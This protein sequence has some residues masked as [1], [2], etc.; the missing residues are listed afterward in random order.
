[1]RPCISRLMSAPNS[2]QRRRPSPFPISVTLVAGSSF[3]FLCRRLR[4]GRSAVPLRS[5]CQLL[6]PVDYIVL[7]RL[8]ISFSVLG[9][10][11]KM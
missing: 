2:I 10:R 7:R 8:L 5:S 9:C 6:P 1:M 3:W 4:K 11:R